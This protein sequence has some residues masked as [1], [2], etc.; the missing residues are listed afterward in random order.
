MCKHISYFGTN[1]FL[2]KLQGVFSTRYFA[3]L[4]LIRRSVI[5]LFTF[6]SSCE[7][8]KFLNFQIFE[9]I[10]VYLSIA[11]LLLSRRGLPSFDYK[12]IIYK[13]TS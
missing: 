13:H 1:E 6:H 11:T 10:P 4:T 5:F 3:K 9:T 12:K 2:S 8:S 7:F